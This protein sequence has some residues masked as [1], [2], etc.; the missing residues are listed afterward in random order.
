MPNEV[1]ASDDWPPKQPSATTRHRLQHRSQKLLATLL[2]DGARLGL[3]PLTWTLADNGSLT[4]T[5][6]MLDSTVDEQR[7]N[8]RRWA[9]HVGATVESNPY[10]EFTE[11]LYAH[12][13]M[14]V[15]GEAE[16]V[17]GHFRATLTFL[18]S[19]GLADFLS[20][21]EPPLV[22]IV[23]PESGGRV[24]AQLLQWCQAPA[25]HWSAEVTLSV[26]P[27]ALAQI[28]GEDY[29]D[30]P[31]SR[32]RLQGNTYV[33]SVDT[34]P[35]PSTAEVHTVGC[36]TIAD[37]AEWTRIIPVATAGDAR[38]V[39]DRFEVTACSTCNPQP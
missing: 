35:Q 15:P 11:E 23:F 28:A 25:G 13:E 2:A 14:E 5:T 17:A 10:S 29:A 9:D 24:G 3:P 7:E 8:I 20:A 4:G 30:V 21:V 34:R 19:V 36:Q 1:A 37:P 27:L 18:P 26:P 32:E 6:N 33:V 31:R 38:K 22:H 16:P 12:W 39:I